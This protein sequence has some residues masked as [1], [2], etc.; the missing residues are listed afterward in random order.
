M[1]D[2]TQLLV[3]KWNLYCEATNCHDDMIYWNSEEFFA[4]HN[5]QIRHVSAAVKNNRYNFDHDW[6]TLDGYANPMS[7]DDPIDFMDHDLLEEWDDAQFSDDYD[8]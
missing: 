2:E 3:I 1:T 4:D 7:S 8:D 6:V 5:L